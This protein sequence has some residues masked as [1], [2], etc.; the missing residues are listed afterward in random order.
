MWVSKT[1][2]PQL[3]QHQFA[4]QV[5][6][7]GHVLDV[8]HINQLVQLIGNLADHGIGAGRHQGQARYRRIIGRGDRE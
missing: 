6:A 7:S 4:L 3:E 1:R 2:D 8:H 5:F